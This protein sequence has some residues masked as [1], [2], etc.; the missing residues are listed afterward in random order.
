MSNVA[1]KEGIE[2]TDEEKISRWRQEEL[3]RAGFSKPHAEKLA[4]RHSGPEAI[5]LHEAIEL[6]TP[7]EQGGKGCD[8]HIAIDILR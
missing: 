3:E 1:V 8:P 7:K 4:V 2:E 5:D 6:V